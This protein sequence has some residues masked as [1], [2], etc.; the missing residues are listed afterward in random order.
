[1]IFFLNIGLGMI[2]GPFWEC[3]DEVFGAVHWAL[4][5]SLG[6]IARVTGVFGRQRSWVRRKARPSVTISAGQ[7]QTCV[8]W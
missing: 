2:R 6:V 4:L 8:L 5:T 7:L 3:H 1:M